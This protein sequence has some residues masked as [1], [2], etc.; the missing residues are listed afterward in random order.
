MLSDKM[1]VNLVLETIRLL[2]LT[3][4]SPKTPLCLDWIIWQVA[5]SWQSQEEDYSTSKSFIPPHCP[6]ARTQQLR[7]CADSNIE[8]RRQ[9][10]FVRLNKVVR[11]KESDRMENVWRSWTQYATTHP[12]WLL[13]LLLLLLWLMLWLRLRCWGHN[14][15]VKIVRIEFWL[16]F[17]QVSQTLHFYCHL[18]ASKVLVTCKHSCINVL[19]FLC[20]GSAALLVWELLTLR[21]PERDCSHALDCTDSAWH[22]GAGDVTSLQSLHSALSLDTPDHWTQAA[23]GG[24]EHWLLITLLLLQ[25]Q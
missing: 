16:D 14:I 23:G 4:G 11:G 25:H 6:A 18:A 9:K 2:G 12:F 22:R 15:V 13:R 3:A 5:S 7:T 24:A 21:G 20:A 1:A 8:T 17:W 19:T 10:T